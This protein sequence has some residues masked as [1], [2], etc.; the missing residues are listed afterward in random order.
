LSRRECSDRWRFGNRSRKWDRNG[1]NSVDVDESR[2]KRQ[3]RRKE[4]YGDG[5]GRFDGVVGVFVMR[6][7]RFG[8][9]R[10]LRPSALRSWRCDSETIVYVSEDIGRWS[11]V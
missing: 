6:K 10:A 2:D 8:G 1:S 3:L 5:Y 7:S 11:R 4:R 9:D